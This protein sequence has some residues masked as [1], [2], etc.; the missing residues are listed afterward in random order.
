MSDNGATPVSASPRPDAREKLK[1]AEYK[2]GPGKGIIA[3]AI[4]A[5]IGLIAAGI[6]F[7]AL[8]KKN[9]DTKITANDNKSMPLN[10]LAGGNG[11]KVLPEKAKSNAKT[12]DIYFDYQCPYCK[13]FENAQGKNVIKAAEDG[14]IKLTYH[15]KTFLDGNIPG[16]NSL[17]AANAGYCA[18]NQNKLAEFTQ[19]VFNNQP[20]E[21]VGYTNGKLLDLGKEAGIKGA[22]YD[23]FKTCINNSTYNNYAKLTEDKTSSDG[24]NAT[25]TIKV[26]GKKITDAEAAGLSN[27]PRTQKVTLDQILARY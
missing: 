2:S 5:I 27:D 23:K 1:K 14:K 3:T 22:A 11:I 10:A 7:F 16:N 4:L 24:V 9:D 19:T 25:P 18:A 12:M 15:I 20:E 17:R 6:V 13:Q 8:D 26:N 21:G